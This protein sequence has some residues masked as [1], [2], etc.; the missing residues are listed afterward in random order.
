[1]K[2]V[3][4]LI[5][6]LLSIFLSVILMLSPADAIDKFIFLTFVTGIYLLLIYLVWPIG[7]NYSSFEFNRLYIVLGIV[8]FLAAAE[9]TFT[10]QCLSLPFT[11]LPFQNKTSILAN[12]ISSTCTYLGKYPTSLLLC[13]LGA[14]LIYSGLTKKPNSRLSSRANINYF[15]KR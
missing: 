11:P 7:T 3:K 8:T 9:V 6:L 12:A 14:Y 4:Y 5:I 10:N 2:L 15:K 13:I 1:M